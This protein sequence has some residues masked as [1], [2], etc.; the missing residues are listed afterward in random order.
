M[1]PYVTIITPVRD[2]AG[3]QLSSL[4]ERLTRL[5]YSKKRLR[6]IAVEGD[7]VDDTL[8]QLEQWTMKVK[9]L[10][11]VKH[12]TGKARFGHVVSVERFRHLAGIINAGIKAAIADNPSTSSGRGWADYIMCIPSDVDFEP[13]LINRL[14]THDKRLIAP[15]F[16]TEEGGGLRFYDT[17]AFSRDGLS[18]PPFN[19]TWYQA[20]Y[21][22]RPME[23]DTV[24]G[25]VLVQADLFRQGLRYSE[26]N[27]DRG[28]CE[29]VR[30]MGHSIWADPT[31]H[32]VHL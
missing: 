27:L 12:D 21:P 28:L 22:Q 24:G 14:L 15:M 18:L 16:W 30:A 20:N 5:D 29:Q 26:F 11:I 19:F 10:T 1:S 23:M 6:F 7:S 9:Q 31:T 4:I 3:R 13:D 8:D 32:V 25:C 17:W 2:I